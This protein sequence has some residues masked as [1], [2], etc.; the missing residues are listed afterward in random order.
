MPQGLEMNPQLHIKEVETVA[1]AP[2]ASRESRAGLTP[3]PLW[4]LNGAIGD[5]RLF[6]P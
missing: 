1:G 5:G 3:L 2:R 6:V 4:A